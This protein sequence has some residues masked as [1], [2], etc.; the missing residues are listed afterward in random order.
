MNR[1]PFDEALLLGVGLYAGGAAVRVVMLVFR[2]S[3]PPWTS[4]LGAGSL[5]LAALLALC[6]APSMPTAWAATLAIS[7]ATPLMVWPTRGKGR[8]GGVGVRV[9]CV[10]SNQSAFWFSPFIFFCFSAAAHIE[11]TF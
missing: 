7:A 8:G 4:M 1:R 3:P 10:E 5:S 6:A 11:N 2:L 9:A